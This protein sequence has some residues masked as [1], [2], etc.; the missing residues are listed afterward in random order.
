MNKNDKTSATRERPRKWPSSMNLACAPANHSVKI[1][2]F[3]VSVVKYL[4]TYFKTLT[5]IQQVCCVQFL[6]SFQTPKKHPGIVEVR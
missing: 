3:V 2:G 6:S 5:R 1:A 4:L